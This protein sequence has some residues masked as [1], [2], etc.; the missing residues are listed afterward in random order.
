[1]FV[2]ILSL[3]STLLV[4]AQS[5]ALPIV[6][7]TYGYPDGIGGLIIEVPTNYPNGPSAWTPNNTWGAYGIIIAPG[8]L[9]RT[10]CEPIPA[11]SPFINSS[12]EPVALKKNKVCMIGCNMTQIS[13]GGSDPCN[14][15][16]IETPSNSPMSCWDIGTM[17]GGYGVCAYNCSALIPNAPHLTPC[18]QGNFGNG[19]CELYCDTRTF[20]N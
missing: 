11:N 3:T 7:Q 20:P 5:G 8:S 4:R 1:M 6:N 2:V 12:L 10:G 15:G 9:N 13:N 14:I 16:S 17:A 18:S 19:T